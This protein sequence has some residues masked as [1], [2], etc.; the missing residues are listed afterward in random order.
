MQKE[1]RNGGTAEGKKLTSETNRDAAERRRRERERARQADR[2]Q[3][4]HQS[5][6]S[7]DAVAVVSHKDI[8]LDI[9]PPPALKLRF[10]PK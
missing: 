3:P 9:I 2:I 8:L 6:R 7:V 1:R 4:S 5:I 10:R